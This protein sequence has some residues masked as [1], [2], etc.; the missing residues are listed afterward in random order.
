M[1]AWIMGTAIVIFRFNP[2]LM[3]ERLGPRKGAKPWNTAIMSILGLT[4]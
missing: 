2:N 1:L 3:A 4:Q